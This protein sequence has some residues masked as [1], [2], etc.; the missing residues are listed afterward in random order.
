MARVRFMNREDL[1]HVLVVFLKQRLHAARFPI[2]GRWTDR[3][4][5]WRLGLERR[6]RIEIRERITSLHLRHFND[7]AAVR[8]GQFEDVLLANEFFD[9]VNCGPP[10]LYELLRLAMFLA[11]RVDY[12]RDRLSRLGREWL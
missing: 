6:G 10:I 3:V 2:R 5:A 7:L 8:L 11:H 12:L 1:Q 9:A 4:K